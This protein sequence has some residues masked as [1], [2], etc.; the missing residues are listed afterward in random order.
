VA[1]LDRFEQSGFDEDADLNVP[2][3]EIVS[4]AKVAGYPLEEMLAERGLV[5]PGTSESA[6]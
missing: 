5:M 6:S 4:M 3:E 1:R 2:K